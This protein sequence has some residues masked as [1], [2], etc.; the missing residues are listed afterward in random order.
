MN[1]TIDT[2]EVVNTAS[3]ECLNVQTFKRARKL[4]RM[5]FH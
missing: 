1:Y 3:M 5:Q 4:R 2:A